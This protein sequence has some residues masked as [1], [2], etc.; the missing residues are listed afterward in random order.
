M[1]LPA[2]LKEKQTKK[3]KLIQELIHKRKCGLCREQRLSAGLG[4]VE[5]TFLGS[6]E[7]PQGTVTK[8]YRGWLHRCV[9]ASALC[10]SKLQQTQQLLLKGIGEPGHEPGKETVQRHLRMSYVKSACHTISHLPFFSHCL[11]LLYPRLHFLSCIFNLTHSWQ[12]MFQ[13]P[14]ESS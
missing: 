4:S 1:L 7:C 9:C 5:T 6:M 8:A 13:H 10:L 12:K 3:G 11:Y 14:T 2:Q